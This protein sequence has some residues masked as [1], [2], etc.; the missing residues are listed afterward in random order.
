MGTPHLEVVADS[1]LSSPSDEI[2]LS[3]EAL[4]LAIA[5]DDIHAFAELV[6]RYEQAVRRFCAAIIYDDALGRDV[7]QEVFLRLWRLRFRYRSQGKLRQLIF[8]IARN[9]SRSARRRQMLRGLWQDSGA[10][11]EASLET[12]PD[13]TID[14]QRLVRGALGQLDRRYRLPV[15]LRY[16]GGLDYEEIA[17]VM[18]LN[19]S[20]TRSRV[21]YGLKR[22]AELLAG[23]ELR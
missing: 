16:F 2:P 4:M 23:E 19:T 22:L 20:T 17:A 15:A 5:A 14:R 12:D 1:R 18:G 3:D 9:L 13:G 10:R 21:F 7:A 8:V 11:P 6:R